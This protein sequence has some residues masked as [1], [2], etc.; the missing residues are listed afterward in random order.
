MSFN[1]K[2]ALVISSVIDLQNIS[3]NI[4]GINVEKALDIFGGDSESLL[5]VLRSF[6]I[7]T[8]PLLKKI[9]NINEENLADYAIIIHGIKGSSRSIS[10]EMVGNLAE[11]LEKA[12]KK[13]NLI[14]VSAY[15]NNFIEMTESLICDIEETLNK[16]N[17][18]MQ[19]PK[20]DKPGNDELA[21]LFTACKEYDMDG[22]D[23]VM[24]EIEGFEYYSDHGLAQ[25]L[26]EN[27]DQV[28]F[29]QIMD[30][31]SSMDI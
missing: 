16:I 3:D 14:F 11:A 22:V 10:A 4:P 28:N 13:K 6:A 17:A 26:R 21:R 18:D 9:Q 5:H 8:R 25:W 2:A 12:A 29:I 23:A 24:A 15:N 31:I 30:K 20:R 7:N 19:K 27:V 1:F